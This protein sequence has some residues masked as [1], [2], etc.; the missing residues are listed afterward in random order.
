MK[1]E[2]RGKNECGKR[3]AH[4]RKEQNRNSS[5]PKMAQA[6]MVVALKEYGLKMTQSSYS[7]L[8]TGYRNIKDYELIAIIKV[9]G[10]KDINWLL[11][12]DE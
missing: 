10:I 4:F 2:T 5:A 3:I 9:L 11:F 8:E 1:A 6:D 7:D 12:G